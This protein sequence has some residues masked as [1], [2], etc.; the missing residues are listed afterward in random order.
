MV[1]YGSIY[2]YTVAK[3]KN[4]TSYFSGSIERNFTKL[5]QCGEGLN[6]K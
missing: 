4:S 5:G 1:V 6:T 3:I 2:V